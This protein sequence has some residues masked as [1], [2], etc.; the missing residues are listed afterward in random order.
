MSIQP[1]QPYVLIVEG[2]VSPPIAYRPMRQRLIER[3]ATGVDLAP[4]H[5]HDW[6]LAAVRGFGALRANVATAIR[7]AHERAGGQRI[8]VVGHSGGG[9]LARLAVS[10]I[11]GDGRIEGISAM[12][13]CLVTLGTPHDLH[14]MQTRWQHEGVRLARTL[15]D[16]SP[17]AWFAPAMGYVTV[18]S[19]AVRPDGDDAGRPGGR[20]PLRAARDWFFRSIVG[21]PLP[22]GSDGVVSVDVAHL[23][24]ARQL[25][26]HDVH[27]G[28]VG[29]PWYGD[30]PVIDRWWPVAID[31]W[32]VALTEQAGPGVG[33]PS[34]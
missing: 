17:G 32:R 4:V 2:L 22:G 31:A 27:H 14:W 21:A 13:G 5:V 10:D 20:S 30:S 34:R 28:V 33:D 29:S 18:A 12:V 1:G 25:T 7:T 6:M 3:G 24:G 19:D 11:P 15:A 8:M 26:F 23:A 9:L 16:S